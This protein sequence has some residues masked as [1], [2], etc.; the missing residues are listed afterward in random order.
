LLD[1]Y[2]FTENDALVISRNSTEK[3]RMD[4]NKNH[5]FSV[6]VECGRWEDPHLVDNQNDQCDLRVKMSAEF[7]CPVFSLNYFVRF[8][9]LTFVMFGVFL[10]VCATYVQKDFSSMLVKIFMFVLI[11]QLLGALHFY[12]RQISQNNAMLFALAAILSACSAIFFGR[13]FRT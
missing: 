12:T 11:M 13:F 5:T 6:L 7:G 1:A 3:C 2:V 4:E 8:I 10:T 9:G